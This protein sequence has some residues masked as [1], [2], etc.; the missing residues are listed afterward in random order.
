M[1]LMEEYE[2]KMQDVKMAESDKAAM[3]AELHAKMAEI[4]DNI[5]TEE[6]I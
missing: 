2:A 5:R 3:M 6:E 4:N 1:R